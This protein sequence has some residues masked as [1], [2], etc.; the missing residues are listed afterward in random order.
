MESARECA[1]NEAQWQKHVVVLIWVALAILL[2]AGGGLMYAK[3]H[4]W[5]TPAYAHDTPLPRLLP[6]NP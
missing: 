3:A 5:F 1:E 4:G 6:E 2:V